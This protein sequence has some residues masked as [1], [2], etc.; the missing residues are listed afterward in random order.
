MGVPETD[1]IVCA[2]LKLL[3]GVVNGPDFRGTS[4]GVGIGV[5][6]ILCFV[7]DRPDMGWF[8]C[9]AENERFCEKDCWFGVA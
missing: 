2:A 7:G 5:A 8:V 3:D 4:V 9:D 1:R 6:E